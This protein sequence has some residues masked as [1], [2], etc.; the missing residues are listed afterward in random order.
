M[1]G[2]LPFVICGIFILMLRDV[3]IIMYFSN[4]YYFVK[5]N[6]YTVINKQ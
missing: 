3:L 5:Y 1:N 2:I 4:T 6:Y